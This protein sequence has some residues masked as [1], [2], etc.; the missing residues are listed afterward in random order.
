MV[1]STL[2]PFP[3]LSLLNQSEKQQMQE[4][5]GLISFSGSLRDDFLINPLQN[6]RLL[7]YRKYISNRGE[8]NKSPWYQKL[9]L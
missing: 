1:L 2:L 7:Q 5:G 9:G 3:T 8:E 4:F 6:C